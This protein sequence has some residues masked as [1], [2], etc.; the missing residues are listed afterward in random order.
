[1]SIYV[2]AKWKYG[3][4]SVTPDPQP[5]GKLKGYYL[6]MSR[7][8]ERT[9][10][11][12]AAE[13]TLA[14]LGLP[15]EAINV[16]VVPAS[17]DEWPGT[18]YVLGD[19]VDT[20]GIDG[21]LDAYR[22][23]GVNT[24]IDRNGYA[25]P[26]PTFNSQAEEH[27]A[28]LARWLEA[29]TQ[30]TVGGRTTASPTPDPLSDI[31]TGQI[32]EPNV[33]VFDFNGELELSASS[34]WEVDSWCA[35]TTVT[36]NLRTASSSGIVGFEIYVNGSVG[37]GGTIAVGATRSYGTVYVELVPGD[38]LGV[39]LTGIGTGASSLT[40]QYTAAP[41]FLQEGAG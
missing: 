1:M 9:A 16:S 11:I 5:P 30:G 24:S 18:G 4:L 14:S 19:A 33:P 20:L 41:T 22:F 3:Y 36:A 29:L 26:L 21:T 28:R 35:L 17:S 7:L 12:A 38:Y 39:L 37:Y 15:S 23:V 6:D 8:S 32:S 40:V 13:A 25:I 31:P 34:L 27:T 2:L 10:V